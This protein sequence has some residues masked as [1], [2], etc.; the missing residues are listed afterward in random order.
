MS[1][2]GTVD[3]ARGAFKFGDVEVQ[4]NMRLDSFR[5]TDLARDGKI[6]IKPGNRATYLTTWQLA[7]SEFSVLLQFMDDQLRVITMSLVLPGERLGTPEAEAAHTEVERRRKH[8]Q[9]L[10][11]W[12][13]EPPYKFSWGEVRSA[14]DFKT[15]DSL[16]TFLF[17]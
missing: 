15:G 7:E 2:S 1:H 5:Q 12:F 14:G 6:R 9:I 16:I 11:R 17:K 10:Y 3:C 4:P 8:D 13:G